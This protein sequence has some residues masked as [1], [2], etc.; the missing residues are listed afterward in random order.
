MLL[1]DQ[2]FAES[3]GTCSKTSACSTIQLELFCLKSTC[4]PAHVHL[5]PPQGQDGMAVWDAGTE[6]C[7]EA[8]LGTRLPA[9]G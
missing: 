3:M 7:L 1:G 4:D 9:A 2:A 8:P 5:P 6:P